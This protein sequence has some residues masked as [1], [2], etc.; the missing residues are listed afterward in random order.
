MAEN[1]SNSFL[2]NT[3]YYLLNFEK[4]ASFQDAVRQAAINNNFQIVLFS[5]D[6]NTIFS[7]ETKHT[8]SIESAIHARIEKSK[9]AEFNPAAQG[10]R[11]EVNGVVTYWGPVTIQAERYYLMLVDNENTYSQDEILKLAEIIQLA[12]GM[13]NYIPK[14]DATAELIRAI[15]RGNRSL[16]NA[17]L[18]ELGIPE[19]DL[20]GIFYIPGFKK[21]DAI[22]IFNAFES[23]YGLRLLKVYE[24]DEVA[25][26]ILR[27]EN[28]IKPCEYDEWNN[29]TRSLYKMGVKN[30]FLIQHS[31]TVEGLCNGFH[32]INETI[33]FVN[34]IFPR[35]RLF[36]KYEL[37]FVSN[38]VSVSFQGGATK[39]NYLDLVKA[40]KKS[41]DK[42]TRELEE[43][44]GVFILDSGL[45][46]SRCA[47][48]MDVHSNTIQYRLKRIREILGLDITATTIVPGLM[49]AMAISRID[50]DALN[51]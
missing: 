37:A 19:R 29:L 12:M 24:Q 4:Y 10:S 48:I 34:Y 42:K 35:K 17:L 15:R 36:S 22:N 30:V 13:W 32:L 2:V 44:L 20:D 43:T 38:A 25:G 40:F 31:N 49:M 8:T 11:V 1:F 45:S 21:S 47:R 41:P 28:V 7:V 14:R 39:K 27:S 16:A 50:K 3:I 51:R 6:F 33:G 5:N 9:E 46:T 26:I 23:E 18:E